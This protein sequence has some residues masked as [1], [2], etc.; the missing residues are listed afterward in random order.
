M[1]NGFRFAWR[2]LGI[3]LRDFFLGFDFKRIQ[4]IVGL[5]ALSFAPGH[6]DMRTLAVLRGNFHAQLLGACGC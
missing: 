2:E 5:D 6:L 1:R 3:P 4:Q